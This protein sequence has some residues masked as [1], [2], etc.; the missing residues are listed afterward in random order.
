MLTY[1]KTKILFTGDAEAEARNKIY[2]K[3]SGKLK[4]DVLKVAH[5]GSYNGTDKQFLEFVKPSIALISCGVNN[6]FG[7]PHQEAISA[8]EQK[9]IKIYRTDE[10]GFVTLISDK[11]K[12][13]VKKEENIFDKIT[14]KFSDTPAYSVKFD[15]S[16]FLNPKDWKISGFEERIDYPDGALSLTSMPGEEIYNYNSELPIIMRKMN[17]LDKW[18]AVL[19]MTGSK[20]P[21]TDGAMLIYENR[22]NWFSF[23]SAEDKTLSLTYSDNGKPHIEYFNLEK[24]PKYFA[25]EYYNKKMNFAVSQDRKTWYVV[26]RYSSKEFHFEPAAIQIGLSAN[27]WKNKPGTAYFF[28]YSEYI[29]K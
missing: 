5:H 24:M 14:Y 2:A 16:K 17:I 10:D 28:D 11:Q 6:H 26:R 8:L 15:D 3:F 4:A 1:G 18:V 21:G 27:S 19:N 13:T 7:H 29:T 9:K 12:W 25:V 22:S 23:S 20:A